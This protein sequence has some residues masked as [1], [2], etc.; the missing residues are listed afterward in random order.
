MREISK[1][2]F[3]NNRIKDI[4]S[5]F[6]GTETAVLSSD[7]YYSTYFS[8]I[9]FNETNKSET[10]SKLEER[11][12]I[13]L[14]AA[15]SHYKNWGLLFLILL[16]FVYFFG[17]ILRDYFIEI[18]GGWEGSIDFYFAYFMWVILCIL[19]PLIAGVGY[20]TSSGK[21]KKYL[22]IYKAENMSNLIS[23]S[24]KD[25][26]IILSKKER[27]NELENLLIDELITHEEYNEKR[28]KIIDDL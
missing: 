9:K 25:Y 8:D 20:I 14:E 2:E 12:W 7:R 23:H 1:K 21:L 16:P 19:M 26:S 17:S 3:I 10:E 27:L 11:F 4:I 5:K 13:A 22:T 6:P 28:N 15:V 18:S 24:N